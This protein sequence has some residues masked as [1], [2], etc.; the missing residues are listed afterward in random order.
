HTRPQR[1]NFGIAIF[2][3]IPLDDLTI[4]SLGNNYPAL[5]AKLNFG[6]T[7]ITVVGIHPMSPMSQARHEFRNWQLKKAG[8]L[9]AETPGEKALL[10]D[11][12]CTSWSPAFR[13]LLAR[14]GLRDSRLGRGVQPSWP[15]GLPSLLRI[16]IDHCLVSGGLEV[17]NRRTGPDIGSDH[18]PIVVDL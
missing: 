7:P 16:P 5:I 17:E 1:N 11:L 6:G 15:T 9:L 12:N 10:G 8:K 14:S 18:L 3:R 13:D 4:E 2:S